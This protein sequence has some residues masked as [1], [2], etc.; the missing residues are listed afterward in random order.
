MLT[1]SYLPSKR[2]KLFGLYFPQNWEPKL[3]LL[4]YPAC[5]WVWILARTRMES[6]LQSFSFRRPDSLHRCSSE[7]YSNH[8]YGL[9]LTS[10]NHTFDKIYWSD[11][12]TKFADMIDR[13]QYEFQA[14]LRSHW[15]HFVFPSSIEE[16]GLPHHQNH[17]LQPP[18]HLLAGFLLLGYWATALTWGVSSCPSP[19]SIA[20]N[21]RWRNCTASWIFRSV[22]G[23]C[24]FTRW[25]HRSWPASPAWQFRAASFAF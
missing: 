22:S 7:S 4:E 12:S 23:S 21:W 25:A 13:L 14:D 2:K 1:A 8:T 3:S 17:P 9:L 18:V 15:A 20:A 5:G 11:L 10:L 24:G 16:A 19:A 6:C